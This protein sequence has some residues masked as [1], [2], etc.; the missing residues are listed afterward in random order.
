MNENVPAGDDPLISAIII[1][2]ITAGYTLAPP[3]KDRSTKQFN[4]LPPIFLK[5]L[6]GLVLIGFIFPL[7][8]LSSVTYS[9]LLSSNI[10]V[11]LPHNSGESLK[12]LINTSI[13]PIIFVSVQSLSKN[14]T[15]IARR[16][17]AYLGVFTNNNKSDPRLNILILFIAALFLN[18]IFC[19][20]IVVSSSPLISILGWWLLMTLYW[21]FLISL[22]EE[23]SRVDEHLIFIL[24]Y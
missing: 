3:K 18:I 12:T 22:W 14:F 16:I 19:C 2:G 8:V 13:Y 7:I 23:Y 10:S 20:L 15:D 17:S 6:E 24:F 11:L 4:F 9:T 21:F 1:L 5:I